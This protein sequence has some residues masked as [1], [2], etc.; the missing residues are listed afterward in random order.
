MNNCGVPAARIFNCASTLMPIRLL[1]LPDRWMQAKPSQAERINPFPTRCGAKFSGALPGCVA[2]TVS[3]I[4]P[5][6]ATGDNR[7]RRCPNSPIKK[8]ERLWSFVF[9]P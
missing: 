8:H 1:R 4:V 5:N 3:S 7:I 2:D 6:R 9:F